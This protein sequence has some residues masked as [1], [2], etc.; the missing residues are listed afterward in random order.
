MTFIIRIVENIIDLYKD[1]K[2][3]RLFNVLYSTLFNK[4]PSRFD[5][6]VFQ[7]QKSLYVK[8]DI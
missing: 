5:G 2:K 3:M 8:K 4:R 7:L 6:H 1:T